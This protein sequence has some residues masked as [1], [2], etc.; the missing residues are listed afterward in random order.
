[1]S[2]KSYREAINEAI[3]QEMRRDENVLVWG[4]EATVNKMLGEVYLA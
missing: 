3:A 4:E 2:K 1:M